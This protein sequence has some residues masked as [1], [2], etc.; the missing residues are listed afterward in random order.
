MPHESKRTVHIALVANLAIAAAKAAAGALSGSA[1]MLAEAAHSFADTTNQAFLLVSLSLGERPADENHPFGYGKERF[2]WAFMAA[3]FIFVSGAVFSIGQGVLH[4][5]S[6]PEEGSSEIV[7]NYVVLGFALIAE[8]V[9]WLRALRQVR[10]EAADAGKPL[11]TYVRQSRDPTVKTVLSEDSAAIAGL[12]LALLGVGLHQLTGNP[13]FDAGASI[14]IGLLLAYVAYELGRDTKGLLLGEA[15]H[16]EERD[17]I[18]DSIRA[19]DEVDEVVELLTMAL[20]PNNLLVT[21]RLDLSDGTTADRVEELCREIDAELRQ[22]IPGV[23]QVFL[24]PTSR[25]EQ[26]EGIG[27]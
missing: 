6:P 1:A 2:F 9:S 18:R 24:D 3:A 25:A 5:L 8:T 21:A 4:F 7:A 13:R 15:A 20:G 11:L 14:V 26:S 22:K 23:K 12:V 10:G 17:Q 19:H 16:P 27:T